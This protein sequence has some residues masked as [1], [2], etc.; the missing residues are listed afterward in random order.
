VAARC[1]AELAAWGRLQQELENL[2]LVGDSIDTLRAEMEALCGQ[3]QTL[4]TALDQHWEAREEREMLRWKADLEKDT[5]AFAQARERDIRMLDKQLK[6]DLAKRARQRQ[7]AREKAARAAAKQVESESAPDAGATTEE[8][9]STEAANGGEQAHSKPVGAKEAA[10]DETKVPESG[11][12]ASG[13]KEEN[14]EAQKEEKVAKEEEPAAAS[15]QEET[16]AVKDEVTAKGEE[17]APE[18][19][20][21]K[22]PAETPEQEQEVDE[23][24]IS[25]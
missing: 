6:A 18:E 3:L 19:E 22:E 16:V 8:T 25:Q 7:I 23:V 12:G 1:E 2:S 17:S 5:D 13:N 24:E 21:A 4:D 20:K 14:K 11:T 15:K 10:A 9:A